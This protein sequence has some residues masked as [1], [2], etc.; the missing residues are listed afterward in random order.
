MKIAYTGGGTGGHMYPIIAV[1]EELIDIYDDEKFVDQGVYF[2]SNAPYNEELLQRNFIEYVHV[3]AGKMRMYPSFQ[4]V[5][6]LFKTFYGIIVAF[7][8]LYQI[9]PD[10][11]FG[12]GG[13]ASFPTVFAAWM[14]GIPIVI[15]ESDVAPGRANTLCGRFASFICVSYEEAR[16]YFAKKDKVIHTGQPIR[17]ALQASVDDEFAYEGINHNKKTL[18]VIG[19][20]QGAQIFNNLMIQIAPNLVKTHNILHIAG[21][22]NYANQ[23]QVI[24]SVL[25]NNPD[26]DSYILFEYVDEI[27]LRKL[28][29]SADAALTRAGST[30]FE[31]ACFGLP[32]IVVPFTVSNRDHARKNAFAFAAT[33]AGIVIEEANLSDEIFMQELNFIESDVRFKEAAETFP[34]LQLHRHAAKTIAELLITVAKEHYKQ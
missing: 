3:P 9:M 34:S 23:K 27:L 30:L 4:N 12:K 10:V 7:I 19:G 8:K 2:F 26:K 16:E 33:G 20:S 1:N 31:I 5:I 6:D 15:H 22:K 32:A 11:V 21:A 25:A 29:S 13:Y 24:D 18:L 14:I 17:R 28:Y